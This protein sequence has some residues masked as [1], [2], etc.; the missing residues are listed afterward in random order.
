[1]GTTGST[2]CNIW[3]EILGKSG[4]GSKMTSYLQQ[5]VK[6]SMCENT[7]FVNTLGTHDIAARV[8][9]ICDKL[10]DSRTE[11]MPKY[12][13][14]D[15]VFTDVPRDKVMI[16]Q[17]LLAHVSDYLSTVIMRTPPYPPG[18]F[19]QTHPFHKVILSTR[20]HRTGCHVWRETR[21]D[22]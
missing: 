15:K 7:P 6:A 10:R 8:E 5:G 18:L 22:C 20:P 3:L 4:S 9:L 17:K 2:K 12:G 14:H 19:R 21:H 11:P 16:V 13:T 1:M